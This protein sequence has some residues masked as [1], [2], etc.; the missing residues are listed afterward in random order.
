MRNLA[1]NLDR[2]LGKRREK[3]YFRKLDHRVGKKFSAHLGE[4]LFCG[5]G[6]ET[7]CRQVQEEEEVTL[8]M[9]DGLGGKKAVH[10]TA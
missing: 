5:W 1:F 4:G 9:K 7:V 10:L 2:K 6:K 8:H 3:L